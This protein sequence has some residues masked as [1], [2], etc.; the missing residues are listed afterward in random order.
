MRINTQRIRKA[1]ASG[2][3]VAAAKEIFKARDLEK[4]REAREARSERYGIGVKED[5]H[6]EPPEG[7]PEDEAMYGDPVNYA[8]PAENRERAKAALGYFNQ[9]DAREDGGYTP[10]E[11]TIV[12]RRLARLISE[13]MD[14][15]YE[16]GD[17]ELKRKEEE[18]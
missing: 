3:V 17:G 1:L 11:W 5:S 18:G 14:V 12:G 15:G 6:L 8:W 2:G 7:Y 16:Y 10:A 9:D 4:L 13:R